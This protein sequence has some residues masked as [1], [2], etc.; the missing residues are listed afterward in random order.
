MMLTVLVVPLKVVD[1]A[2]QPQQV[3]PA[4]RMIPGWYMPSVP[5]KKSR[6]KASAL[7][8]ALSI[9]MVAG[10]GQEET[11]SSWLVAA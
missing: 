2:P 1:M 11:P 7:T 5:V 9:S 8:T 6:M 3:C 4:I 10:V